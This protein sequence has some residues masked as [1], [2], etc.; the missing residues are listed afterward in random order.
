MR[1][2]RATSPSASGSGCGSMPT[3][4]ASTPGLVERVASLVQTESAESRIKVV[5]LDLKLT[6]IDPLLMRPGM[7]FRGR[8]E[9]ARDHGVLQLP[10]A[11]IA[12]TASG[13][14]VTKVA[15]AGFRSTAVTLGRRSR[16]MVEIKAGVQ[17]GDRVLLRATRG[18][19]GGK[20]GGAFGLGS[21]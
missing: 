21:S 2:M 18:G 20:S 13:P 10:L 5:Q 11:A 12:S 8:I 15:G 14:M 3:P 17:A 4:T 9:I 7:R 6:E 16:E 19:P 1:S